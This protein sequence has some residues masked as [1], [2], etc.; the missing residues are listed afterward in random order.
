MHVHPHQ[1]PGRHAAR[2]GAV[3]HDDLAEAIVDRSFAQGTSDRPTS[4][5]EFRGWAWASTR[6]FLVDLLWP[7]F[8]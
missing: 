1:V 3:L 8:V 4:W 5:S 2:R 7:V 6:F